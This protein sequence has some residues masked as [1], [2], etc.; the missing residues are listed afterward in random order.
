MGKPQGSQEM[1]Q[2]EMR[3]EMEVLAQGSHRRRR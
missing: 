3:E 1:L 2:E